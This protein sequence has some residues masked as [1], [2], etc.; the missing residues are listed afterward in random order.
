VVD[1]TGA[2]VYFGAN[3]NIGNG[4]NVWLTNGQYFAVGT[5]GFT[6]GASGQFTGNAAGLTNYTPDINSPNMIRT[7]WHDGLVANAAT[8]TAISTNNLPANTLSA[9]GQAIEYVLNGTNSAGSARTMAIYVYYG[10]GHDYIVQSTSTSAGAWEAHIRIVRVSASVVDVYTW[11]QI[12]GATSNINKYTDTGSTASAQ[13]LSV[14]LQSTGGGTAG[15]I[16]CRWGRAQF[17][18]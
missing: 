1:F 17:M 7:L 5:G 18:P 10:T 8:E 14:T 9:N 11:G 12:Q 4:D 2:F 3:L 13:P 16:S 6:A 15:D